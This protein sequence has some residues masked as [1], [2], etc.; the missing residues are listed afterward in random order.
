MKKL[1]ALLLALV[2]V[3]GLVACG[4]KAPAAD[5]PAAD[6]P[7]ADAPAADAPVEYVYP[8]ADIEDYDELSWA[9]YED[10]LGEFYE[11]YQTAK[12][13][14]NIAERHALMAVAEAKLLG[15]GVMLPLG[16]NGGNYAISR[17]APYTATS[18]LW[19]N[20]SY[21]YHNVVVATEPLAPAVRDEMKAKWAELCVD[22]EV[23]YE[24]WAKEFLVEK[25]YTLQDTYTFNYN[26]DP[27]TWDVLATSMA[28]DSE[29]IVNTYDGL[30]EYDAENKLQPAL[31]T[32]WSNTVNADGTETWTFKIREG[33]VW[34]D[35]QGRKVADLTA[36][37]FV[38]GLQHMM[39][40]AGGLEYLAY[41]AAGIVGAY[42]YV[43]GEITDFAEVGV[44]A[45]DDYT[46]QYTL[47]KP[48]SF[49]MTML[50]YGIFAPM[51]R[52]YFESKGGAFGADYNAEAE[53]YTYG[54][55][56]NDIAYC[57]PYVVT[58]AT[59]ENTIVFSANK[60][61]WN[62]DKVGMKTITWMYNDGEDALKAYND[63]MAHVI[64]GAGLNAS[65][66]EAA[67]ADGNFEKYAYVSACDAT[68]FMA[69][70]NLHRVALAN[71]NDESAVVS[72][73]TE[74]QVARAN[75]AMLNQ[76]FRLAVAT[77]TDLATYNA[78]VVGEELK[79]TSLRNMYTP[80]NFVALSEEVTVDIN[81]TATTFPAG[82]QYG[83]ICQAQLDADGIKITVWDPTAEA[84]VGSSDGFAGWYNPDVA[85]EYLAAAIEEMAAEGLEISAENPIYLDLPCWTSS[86]S[87]SNRGNAY[88]QSI[89]AALG[90]AVIVNLVECVD[91]MEWYYAG[92][93]PT[94]GAE[95]NYDICD[96]SG[97]GPDYGDPQ[98]YLD[99]MLPD[100][101][102]YMTKAIGLF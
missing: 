49:F 46:L 91:V 81:G 80:G 48:C 30:V 85:A 79:L 35:S 93:Y 67:K 70:V 83:A 84:G 34:V 51:N 65:S 22:D 45:V 16:S 76:N 74:E 60:S 66:A 25:G 31:A 50:G 19:G 89:E 28:A 1:I 58:N 9:I 92:Y 5:A 71:F 99:T 26:G 62:A 90:G 42:E 54:K 55:T 87:Y 95:G 73:K 4:K 7:A 18:A 11:I 96:L 75:A 78:Q 53:S 15:S 77:A 57:G 43:Y 24:D 23:Y 32:E 69:F 63:T 3:F 100:Y 14:D 47:A 52:A 8:Y 41:E 12:E 17:V 38:A 20:D 37:D 86:E 10:V 97:W 101:A 36:D 98:T 39:D 29:A 82:T 21:R 2:M 64:D 33:A 56:P 68:S 40:A 44:K 61:Y 59:A 6:A 72:P 102:G 27:Q 88:K 94:T 13:A